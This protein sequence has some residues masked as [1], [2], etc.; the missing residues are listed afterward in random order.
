MRYLCRPASRDASTVRH[1]DRIIALD[2]GKIVDEGTHQQLIESYA[3]YRDLA[4]KQL[5]I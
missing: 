5:K 1:A 4:A 2:N 3:L